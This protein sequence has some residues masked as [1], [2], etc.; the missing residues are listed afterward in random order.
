V[1]RPD[2]AWAQCAA[3][4]TCSRGSVFLDGGLPFGDEFAMALRWYWCQLKWRDPAVAHAVDLGVSWKELAVDFWAATGVIARF[5]R[6]K[7]AQ[8]SLQQM[9]EAFAAA[10]RDLDKAEVAK[11]S[12]LWRGRCG[13]TSSL[14]P[15]GQKAAV[16]GLSVRPLLLRSVDVGVVLCG[17]AASKEKGEKEEVVEKWKMRSPP[18]WRRWHRADAD[19]AGGGGGG[20]Q[21]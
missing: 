10:S 2:F 12:W 5:P 21:T 4:F 1:Q 13:R 19:Y 17:L 18:S 15:F 6:H 14:A 7:H 16:T 11:G 20:E 9:A 3:D 8:T